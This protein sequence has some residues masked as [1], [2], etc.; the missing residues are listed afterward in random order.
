MRYLLACKTPLLL[1]VNYRMPYR[2]T[3]HGLI[4][5]SESDFRPLTDENMTADL[6]GLGIPAAFEI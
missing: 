3:Q 2:E 1:H 5:Q 4:A 6:M